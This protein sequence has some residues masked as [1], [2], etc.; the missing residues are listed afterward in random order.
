MSRVDSPSDMIEHVLLG[1]VEA[2]VEGTGPG[3]FV[4]V[5]AQCDGGYHL[6]GEAVDPGVCPVV[7]GH[8]CDLVRVIQVLRQKAHAWARTVSFRHLPSEDSPVSG[9]EI[10]RLLQ[11]KTVGVLVLRE[12]CVTN[13]TSF[14]THVIVKAISTRLQ[15]VDHVVEKALRRP[16]VEA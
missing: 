16:T 12:D 3:Q 1:V 8:P 14:G 6:Q 9:T 13:P 7:L 11:H 15:S 4:E 5:L 10:P 2:V